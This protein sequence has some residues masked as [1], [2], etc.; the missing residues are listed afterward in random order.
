MKNYKLDPEEKDILES[1]EQGKWKPSKDFDKEAKLIR[2]AAAQ[3]LRK[4]SRVNIRIAT[5][6]LDGLRSRAAE[7][8]IPYQT[9][10]SSILH[11]YVVG[12]LVP[13]KV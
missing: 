6:D 13:V 4:D 3:T 9:L 2:M 7:E 1:F 8:G 11:K 5:R 12:R 10:M